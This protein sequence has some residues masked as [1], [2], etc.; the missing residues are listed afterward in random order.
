MI[1][2]LDREEILSK[3]RALMDVIEA[4]APFD[5]EKQAPEDTWREVL[6]GRY[7][8]WSDGQAFL[9]GEPFVD[10]VEGHAVSGYCVA[11]LAAPL[12]RVKAC[13]MEFNAMLMARG[14][15]V[16][17]CCGR[18]GWQKIAGMRSTWNHGISIRWLSEPN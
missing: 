3:R 8:V 2:Q 18:K 7:E 6:Q 15:Q 16:M 4:C 13:A 1:V 10:S 14:F 9:L 12:H 5:V 17:E 11:Y